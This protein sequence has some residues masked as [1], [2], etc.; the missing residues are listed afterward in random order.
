[1]IL[2]KATTKTSGCCSI[3][4]V[5]WPQDSV[6]VEP[7]FHRG[8]LLHCPPGGEIRIV[9]LERPDGLALAGGDDDEDQLLHLR[10]QLRCHA[11]RGHP[12]GTLHG[13]RELTTSP[14]QVGS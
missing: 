6:Q 14:C 4:T 2:P 7:Q 13:D 9:R 3:A 5:G 12:V 10:E 11:D 8:T 1:M